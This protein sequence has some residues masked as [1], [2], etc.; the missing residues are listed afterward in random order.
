[1]AKTYDEARQPHLRAVLSQMSAE[2]QKLTWPLQ[3]LHELRDERLRAMVRHAKE[4]SPWHRER[5]AGVDPEG[6][7]GDDLRHLPTMNKADVMANWDHIVTDPRLNL[8]V[9]QA[10]LDKVTEN[11]PEYLFDEFHIVTTGGSSGLTGLFPWD[12]EGWLQAGLGAWRLMPWVIK[13][14]ELSPPRGAFVG[15]AHASHMS[16]AIRA[17]FDTGEASCKVPVTLPLGEIVEALNAFQP[18]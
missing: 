7:T 8:K 17:T 15:A 11:G 16:D 1:M 13:D 10:H 2:A 12:Y 4:N 9:A 5:L 3:R 18:N 6:L 14:L